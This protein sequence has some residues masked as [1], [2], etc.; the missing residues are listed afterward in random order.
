MGGVW[1]WFITLTVMA[2]IAYSGVTS[3]REIR[4]GLA[5]AVCHSGYRVRD[6]R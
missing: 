4:R 1:F 2:I 6:F 5:K 3:G